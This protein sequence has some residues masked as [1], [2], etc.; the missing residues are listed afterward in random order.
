MM[1]VLLIFSVLFG[2][3]IARPEAEYE[4][5]FT[6]WM[7]QH[8]RSYNHDEFRIRYYVWR[9]NLDYIEEFNAKNSEMKLA[10]NHLGD[11]THA[12][13]K[14]YFLGFK[15][16][17]VIP[18]G[19][20][21]SNPVQLPT[22][23]DWTSQG[24]VTGVK[25]QGQCGGC[26]AFSTTGSTEGC[27]Y[28]KNKKLVSLSEQQLIDC[29]SSYGNQGC[30]GGL[31]TSAMD[32]VID[33]RGVDTEASYPYTALDGKCSFKASNVAATLSSYVNVKQGSESDLQQKVYQGPTSIAIDA[34]QNSFQF[35]SSG[36]YSD[37]SCSST[38][39]DHGVLAVGWGTDATSG[40]DYW[41]VK[42][43]WGTGWGLKGYIWIAR[44]A[45]NMCGVATMATL[46]IC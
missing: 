43:S 32:Y 35:Y 27:N 30:N 42:N 14:K 18:E 45:K 21:T 17:E 36:V 3:A 33:N 10:M 8:K 39:L 37:R 41:I 44:N 40:A 25:D 46:P 12:E 9:S 23:W 5:L 1:K 2:L 13:F 15:M 31:M 34:S 19:T 26:W 11:L 7:Q 20:L 16:P 6:S 22:S 38:Q 28:I 4:S 24:A 29:S